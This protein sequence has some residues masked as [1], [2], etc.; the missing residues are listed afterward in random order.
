M[1]YKNV[2]LKCTQEELDAFKANI[3]ISY[4]LRGF[5]QTYNGVL[6]ENPT[7]DPNAKYYVLTVGGRTF[8]QN[9][10]PFVAGFVPITEE[11]AQAIIDEHIAVLVDQ[12]IFAEFAAT[13]E[14]KVQQLQAQ[15]V[16][17]QETINFLLGI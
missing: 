1:I 14:D 15:I 12:I 11:N 3:P 2:E 5:H 6:I 9:H 10:A 8:L 17:M 7:G 13:P 4:E 16:T